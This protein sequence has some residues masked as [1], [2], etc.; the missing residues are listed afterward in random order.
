MGILDTTVSHVYGLAIAVLSGYLLI[1]AVLNILYFLSISKRSP[2]KNG[3]KVSVLIPARNEEDSIGRCLDGLLHQ[4]YSDY[5]IIVLDDNS[6]DGT[7]DIL[8]K[9][10]DTHENLKVIKGKEKPDEWKGKAFALQQLAEAAEGEYLYIADADTVHGTNAV[11]WAVSRLQEKNLDAFSAMPRQ[12]TLSF[13]E[14]LLVPIVY[15]PVIFVPVQLIN[16]AGLKDVSF[17]IGQFF[18][19]RKDAF[20]RFGGM[21]EVK[22]EIT[23]DLAMSRKLKRR[24]FRYRY[25]DSRD[26]FRCRM[27][28]GYRETI[29]GFT[30]NLYDKVSAA[31]ELIAVLIP[32]LFFFLFL[33]GML[34]ISLSAAALFIPAWP[35]HWI[36]LGGAAAFLTAWSLHFI[37]FRQ[38]FWMIFAAPLFIGFFSVMVYYALIRYFR[39]EKPVW[40][41][42]K[43]DLSGTRQ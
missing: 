38:A 6:T 25:Y 29:E 2:V 8:K 32:L 24:G 14:K 27:Y 39:G 11:S 42:R 19:F 43:V 5:E 7:P 1:T 15:L 17:G 12:L 9:Y 33:P 16:A 28:G 36:F 20:F 41:S 31:P 40:K 34:F 22:D 26:R 30:K 21:K 10:R 4:D 18:M 23:E 37:Y 35:V 3:P 13:A